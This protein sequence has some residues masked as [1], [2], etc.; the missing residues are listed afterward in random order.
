VGNGE[1]GSHQEVNIEGS[2]EECLFESLLDCIG[3]KFL[4]LAFNEKRK[5]C[6]EISVV[7]RLQTLTPLVA[8]LERE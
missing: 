8:K 2:R 7:L 4:Q 5:E 1:G 6:I 3:M